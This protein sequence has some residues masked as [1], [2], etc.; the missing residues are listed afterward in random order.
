M[1]EIGA[2]GKRSLAGP[3]TEKSRVRSQSVTAS[4]PKKVRIQPV[5]V[6]RADTQR[7]RR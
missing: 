2:P 5:S 7:D 3:G 1:P 6:F 4:K